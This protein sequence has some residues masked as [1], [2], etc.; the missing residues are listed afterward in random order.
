VDDRLYQSIPLVATRDVP[1]GGLPA[2]A[3]DGLTELL[4]GWW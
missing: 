4:L 2:R 1:V 3:R